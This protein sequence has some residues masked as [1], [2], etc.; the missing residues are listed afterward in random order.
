MVSPIELSSFRAGMSIVKEI[1]FVS[2]DYLIYT[3]LNDF[4]FI[5]DPLELESPTILFV[6]KHN[7]HL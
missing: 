3:N 2:T 5:Y 6:F 7:P 4:L 1:I